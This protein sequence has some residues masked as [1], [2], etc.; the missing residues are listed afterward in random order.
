LVSVDYDASFD[1]GLDLLLGRAFVSTSVALF[2]ME[3]KQGNLKQTRES[4]MHSFDGASLLLLLLHM[5]C[6]V[7]TRRKNGTHHAGCPL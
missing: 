4:K 2:N 5:E 6:S 7:S 3:L 1:G